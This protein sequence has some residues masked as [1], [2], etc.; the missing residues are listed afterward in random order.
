MNTR[1]ITK[2]GSLFGKPNGMPAPGP[3]YTSI[4][5]L[6]EK[7]TL[8]FDFALYYSTDHHGGTG[9]IWMSLCKGNPKDPNHWQ[10]LEE[11]MEN[12]LISQEGL[13]HSPF[14]VDRVQGDGHTETPHIGWVGDRIH[15]T[16]HKDNIPPTQATLLATST[17]G[18]TFHRI[19]GQEDSVVLHYDPSTSYGNGHTGYFRWGSNPFSGIEANYIGYSLHGGTDDYYSCLWVSQDAVDWQRHRVLQPIEGQA[20][21]LSDRMIVWHEMDVDS[22]REQE[23]GSYTA[24]TAVSNR[25]SGADSRI[26]ELYEIHLAPDGVTLLSKA[27][28]VLEVGQEKSLDAEELTSPC[29]I[30][31]EG[32][33]LLIYVGVCNGGEQNTVMVAKVEDE[34]NP[35]PWSTCEDGSRHILRPSRS[36][37]R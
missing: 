37:N 24:I 21:D 8:P 33:D 23:D 31:Y 2:L 32:E 18:L 6:R 9:G 22:I 4:L 28:P 35:T 29:S 26:V 25:A 10:S 30:S 15:L 19:R 5:D 20:L 13:Q 3:Y 16:Y 34:P 1:S 7:S 36:E 27:K 17:D 12:G 11:A 14:F